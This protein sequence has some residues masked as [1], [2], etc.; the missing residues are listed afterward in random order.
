MTEA[1]R[2]T[3]A[4][5]RKPIDRAA[6]LA[7]LARA[8]ASLPWADPAV[9]DRLRR[10]AGGKAEAAINTLH[11]T[12]AAQTYVV[13][14]ATLQAATLALDNATVR[15]SLAARAAKYRAA[16]AAL[17]SVLALNQCPATS[18]PDYSTRALTDLRGCLIEQAQSYEKMPAKAGITQKPTPAMITVRQLRDRLFRG[19]AAPHKPLRLLAEAA[20]GI[21]I[22]RNTVTAALRSP[23][24]RTGGDTGKAKS[25]KITTT[26]NAS[27]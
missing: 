6:Y 10:D 24:K 19:R 12:D 17:D 15:A 4:T 8:D 7:A 26:E 27:N 2:T 1:N 20:L 13:F 22:D 18:I 5:A 11:A 9:L 14:F 3:P 25:K 23:R 21:E 16:A